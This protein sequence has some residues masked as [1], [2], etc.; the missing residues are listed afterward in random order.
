MHDWRTHTQCCKDKTM[1]SYNPEH[2]MTTVT[3]VEVV[4][5]DLLLLNA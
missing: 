3:I 4:F 2:L 1:H 5:A